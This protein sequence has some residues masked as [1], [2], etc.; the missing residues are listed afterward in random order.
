MSMNASYAWV[1]LLTKPSYLDGVRTLWKS[2]RAVGSVHPLVVMTTANLDHSA[3]AALR[4]DGC[5]L[6]E[7]QPV[8]PADHQVTRYAADRFAE[9]WTKLRVF[10]LTQYERVAYLDAD[11]VVLKN[12]DGL[13][14]TSLQRGHAIAACPACTCNPNRIGTYPAS[15]TPDTCAYSH[16]DVA[17]HYFNAGMLVLKPDVGTA[18]RLHERLAV[19][20]DLTRFAF[21]EQDLLNEHFAGRW[22]QLPYVFNALKTLPQAHPDM[23]HLD[24]VRIL[25]YIQ[26]KPWEV[27]MS[28]LT[29][30]HPYAALYQKWWEARAAEPR[31]T[32]PA[33]ARNGHT[34]QR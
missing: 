34:P 29:E 26:E 20:R 2:L 17:A 4:A 33:Q 23:W 21:A 5:R 10:E 27:D 8:T 19:E 11:M 1:T 15:W 31:R 18:V 13:F 14:D 3:V 28:A 24:D 9:V 25:H 6:M 30:T 22:T 7:V 16:P 32:D 12:P